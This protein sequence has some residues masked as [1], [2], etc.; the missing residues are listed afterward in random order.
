MSIHPID[1][2]STHPLTPLS[3]LPFCHLPLSPL[4]YDP[5]LLIHPTNPPYYSPLSPPLAYD[6]A[7]VE[8]QLE[9]GS[10]EEEYY[11]DG[12]GYHNTTSGGVDEYVNMADDLAQRPQS[13]S[14]SQ[15]QLTPLKSALKNSDKQS[16]SSSSSSSSSSL[17]PF[18]QHSQSQQ[19]Q[20]PQSPLSAHHPY[21]RPILVDLG[22]MGTIK[23]TRASRLSDEWMM[24][25]HEGQGQG[26][27]G[28][29]QGLGLGQGLGLP[30]GPDGSKS[31]LAQGSGLGPGLGPGFGSASEQG[32]EDHTLSYSSFSSVNSSAVTS[33]STSPKVAPPPPIQIYVPHTHTN[34]C[35]PTPI[36]IYLPL[37]PQ[38]YY[39]TPILIILPSYTHP[40]ILTYAYPPHTLLYTSS[41][42]T[43]I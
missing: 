13:L 10:E 23:R 42:L 11:Q 19:P 9:D 5:A 38:I 18:S 3:P 16:Q 35:T 14:Q 12:G 28:Q 34:I 39:S 1:I 21:P 2:P 15:S 30:P 25:D 37:H 43:Y 31:G 29:D 26:A 36:Q 17:Q 24:D 6:P 22:T 40:H 33:A 20:P 8:Q 41:I 4:A 27:Q 7:L 32:L